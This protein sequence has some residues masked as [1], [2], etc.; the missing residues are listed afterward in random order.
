MNGYTE[1]QPSV[2]QPIK[3]SK[4]QIIEQQYT[5]LWPVKATF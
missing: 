3:V 2:D 4:L 1:E 5:E